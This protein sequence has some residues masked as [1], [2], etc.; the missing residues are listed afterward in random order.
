[1][2][3]PGHSV[4]SAVLLDSDVLIDH[5]RGHTRLE[6]GAHM[7]VSV[8]TR[9]ELYAGHQR[10]EAAAE[11]LLER[12]GEFDLNP[13]IARRAGRIKRDTGLQIA[14]ALIA[15]TA[16]EHELPL[17]TRNRRHFERVAGLTLHSDGE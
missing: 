12:M 7:S 11:A 16:L 17:M 4:T 10:D 5:M 9:A 15:A 6:I 14:D 13:T 8:V 3:D 2:I 1:V